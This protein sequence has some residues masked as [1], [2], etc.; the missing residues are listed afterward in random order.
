MLPCGRGFC[1]SQPRPC[2]CAETPN[3]PNSRNS[4]RNKQQKTASGTGSRRKERGS[5][6][7]LIFEANRIIRLALRSKVKSEAIRLEGL[8]LSGEKIIKAKRDESEPPGNQFDCRN[9]R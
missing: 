5:C 6:G 3:R 8:T 9:V 1:H 2:V 7:V 4:R